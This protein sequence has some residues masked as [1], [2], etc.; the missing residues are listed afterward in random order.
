MDKPAPAPLSPGLKFAL[1]LGPLLV[2][3][4][5]TL[6]FG[7]VTAAA[8]FAVASVIATAMLYR[9]QRK[10]NWLLIASTLA[11]VTFAALTWWFDDATFLKL[12]V[13]FASA[14]IGLALLVGQA[15]GKQPLRS[16]FDSALQLDEEGWRKFTRRF[17]VFFLFMAATNE[18]VRRLVSDEGYAVAKLAVFFP[19][20]LLFM[21]TQLP[22]LKRHALEPRDGA[23]S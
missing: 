18:V 11:V 9:L 14:A 22:L 3:V 2:L 23:G 4:A 7:L 5:V 10:V 16:M 17:G 1:E 19:L 8:P 21:L 15:L 12:K 6:K 20:P 13:T